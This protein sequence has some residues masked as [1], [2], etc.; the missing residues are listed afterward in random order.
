MLVQNNYIEVYKIFLWV[1]TY[2]SL[3]IAADRRPYTQPQQLMPFLSVYE[4]FE[5]QGGTV[6][7]WRS[8][9]WTWERGTRK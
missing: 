6:G 3:Q 8:V 5:C 4:K 2:I 1:H 7:Y 9:A